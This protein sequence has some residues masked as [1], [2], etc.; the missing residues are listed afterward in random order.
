MGHESLAFGEESIGVEMYVYVLVR[1]HRLEQTFHSVRHYRWLSAT[2][3]ESVYKY[4]FVFDFFYRRN[5]LPNVKS[6]DRSIS[7][8]GAEPTSGIAAI[9]DFHK[10]VH[11]QRYGLG[12]DTLLR[13]PVFPD[14][15]I[16]VE[17]ST[18]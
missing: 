17:N 5:E 13:A 3:I 6:T 11:E 8:I 12:G 2:D 4:S 14:I 9:R 1:R 18:D 16:F 7:C 15:D 10:D